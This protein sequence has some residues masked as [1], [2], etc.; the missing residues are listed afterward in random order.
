MTRGIVVLAAGLSARMGGPNK[1]LQAYRGRPLASWALA[2]AGAVAADKRVIVCGRD[3]AAIAALAP[4]GCTRC[5][6]PTPDDGL[7]SSLRLGLAALGDVRAAGV[8]LA[9]MPDVRP[10][11]VERLFEAL[12]FHYAAV[13]R[14]AG[15]WGNPVVLSS[16][17]TQEAKRLS[18]DAGARALMKRNAARIAFLD[19][20]DAAILR[21]LDTPGDFTS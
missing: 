11:L 21:D 12:K 10:Q 4:P 20:D 9:D 3:A 6:N 14:R 15:E 19:T 1:L 16:E 2:C 8:L 13:P 18:G 5:D 7:A 17:A